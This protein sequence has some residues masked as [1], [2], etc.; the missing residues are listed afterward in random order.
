MRQQQEKLQTQCL[1]HREAGWCCLAVETTPQALGSRQ[2]SLTLRHA[3]RRALL[4][5]APARTTP[6]Q[7]C[8]AT[9][10]K[11]RWQWTTTRASQVHSPCSDDCP[12]HA[13][14]VSMRQAHPLASSMAVLALN[15]PWLPALAE[16]ARV[17]KTGAARTP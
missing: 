6:M 3:I 12:S 2:A 17:V 8:A 10:R 13:Q 9:T 7:T 11:M 16:P 15:A 5:Q 14:S 1:L 4:Y